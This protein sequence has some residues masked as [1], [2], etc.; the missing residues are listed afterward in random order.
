MIRIVLWAEI[1][2]FIRYVGSQV[3]P[4][5]DRFPPTHCRVCS[6]LV[7]LWR[8]FFYAELQHT[9]SLL[10]YLIV[11]PP[12]HP[13]HWA[14][15][16]CAPWAAG[17][18]FCPSSDTLCSGDLYLYTSTPLPLCVILSHSLRP[19]RSSCSLSITFLR[20]STHIHLQ[21]HRQEDT[22]TRKEIAPSLVECRRMVSNPVPVRVGLLGD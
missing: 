19:P 1:Q 8:L 13:S 10:L 14:L 12:L 22:R 11:S 4:S 15:S 7:F 16:V 5:L 6:I 18:I 20:V 2:L 17:D 9:T 21:T 3:C